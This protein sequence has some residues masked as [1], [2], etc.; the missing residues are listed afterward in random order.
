[1]E[2]I[3]KIDGRDVAFESTAGTPRRYRQR[4][5]RDIMVDSKKLISEVGKGG[6][7]TPEALK[8]FE[9]LAYVMAKQADPEVPDTPEEW[10]DTFE[11]FSIYNVLPELLTLWLTSTE[12]LEAPKKNKQQKM[13]ES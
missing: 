7:L 3:I 12:T 9:N 5:N 8:T 10:L 2:K 1:M 11:I 13:T 6:E 4:F